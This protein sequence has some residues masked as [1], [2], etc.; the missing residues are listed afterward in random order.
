MKPVV[1]VWAILT[2]IGLSVDASAQTWTASV[3][4]SYTALGTP[5]PEGFGVTGGNTAL[6]SLRRRVWA[7]AWGSFDASL[8]WRGYG[9]EQEGPRT[10]GVELDAGLVLT[11]RLFGIGEN[12]GLVWIGASVGGYRAPFSTAIGRYR[13]FGVRPSLDVGIRVAAKDGWTVDASCNL[14]RYDVL[15]WQGWSVSASVLGGWSW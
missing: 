2:C 6:V 11:R 15:V 3:G 12:N 9:F 5:R 1:V 7:P 10:V 8:V 13:W 14:R 4:W